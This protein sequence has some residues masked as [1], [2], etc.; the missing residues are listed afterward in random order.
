MHRPARGRRRQWQQTPR[1]NLASS[2]LAL[3]CLP[4]ARTERFPTRFHVAKRRPPRGPN[5][6]ETRFG[7]DLETQW[8][9]VIALSL[10]D[11]LVTWVAVVKRHQI[12]PGNVAAPTPEFALPCG[13]F[14]GHDGNAGPPARVQD[15]PPPGFNLAAA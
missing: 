6:R 12:E 13:V 10:I 9:K 4:C 2:S 5:P 3:S 8:S 15:L 14:K 1:L 7:A 11:V